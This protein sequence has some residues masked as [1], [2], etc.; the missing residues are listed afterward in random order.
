MTILITGATGFLGK[1]IYNRLRDHNTVYGLARKGNTEINADLTEKIPQLP[2]TQVVIHTAGLAHF[3][4]K[5]EV[6]NSMFYKVNV[7]GTRNLLEALE[8]ALP[9][10]FVFISSVAVYGMSE[11]VN[12]P[13]TAALAALDPYGKSK[14]EAEIIISEWCN[15]HKITCTILRLPLIADIDPPGNLGSMVRAIKKGYYFNIGGGTAKKS[16]VYSDDIAGIILKASSLG[17]IYN[18][19]DGYHPSFKEISLEIAR[20]LGVKKPLSLSK[21]IAF[22]MAWAGNIFG[23]KAPINSRKLFK[24][25]STLTF[26]DS[27]A[28]K[29]LGW[30]PSPFLTGF[31]IV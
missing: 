12:I 1:K 20:Q 18:L 21:G 7:Q 23:S 13:E 4:P 19:T 17:G 31:K 22:V 16:I 27:K 5:T 15:R 8:N 29:V 6:E 2:V 9:Q 28:R 26:D 25:L 10:S 30:K 11:G 24:I 3:E 14:I